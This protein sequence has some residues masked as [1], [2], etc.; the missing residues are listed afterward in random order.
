MAADSQMMSN[1]DRLIYMVNQI[2]RNFEAMGH[3]H[4]VEAV[5]DHII[6][7]WDPRM[8]AE[9]GRALDEGAEAFSEVA[10]GAVEGLQKGE[11]PPS[12]TPA[13]M[14]NVADEEGRSD[15]G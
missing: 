9:I 3:D 1:R 14:F 7:F 6:S 8:K 4:A 11:T 10:R 12:Q 2:A 13:T 15:A 5:L